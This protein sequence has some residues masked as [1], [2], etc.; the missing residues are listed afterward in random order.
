[1]N[2]VNRIDRIKQIGFTRAGGSTSHIH[3]SHRASLGQDDRASS[4]P[5]R[6]RVMTDLQTRH[7]GQP[8]WAGRLQACA[9]RKFH[10]LTVPASY[11]L[12]P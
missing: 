2:P 12:H 11:T 3:A 10:P 9:Q 5:G 7:I 8:A 6:E 1:M 4:G